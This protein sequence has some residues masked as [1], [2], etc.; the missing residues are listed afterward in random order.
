[1]P[2][3]LRI[4]LDT[5]VISAHLDARDRTR[6]ELTQLFWSSLA[7]FDAHACP[8]TLDEL[9]STPDSGLRAQLLR[10][11]EQLIL[12]PW[13]DE[14]ERL[15]HDYVRAGAFGPAMIQDARHVACCTV[16]GIPVLIS[17]NFRHLV[18]RTRRIMVNLANSKQGYGQIEIISPPEL[19]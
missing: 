6:Q 13:N 7:G 14:M 11:A 16:S 4:Y 1:M 5:S 18:N 10:L 8:I 2:T 12:L 17:W 9:K 19:V 15:A 3:K